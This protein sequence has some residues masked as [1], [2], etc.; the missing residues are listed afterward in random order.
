[1]TNR[2]TLFAAV[3][4][5]CVLTGAG[6]FVLGQKL[7]SPEDA[8]VEVAAPEPSLIG[9]P[10]ESLALSNDVVVRGDAQFEGAVDL[11]LD[12]SLGD[13][14]TRVV[15]NK[16]PTIDS[17][18]NEG[19]VLIEVSGRPVFL[20]E[21]ELPAFREFKPGLEGDDVLQLE[22]ALKRLGYLEVEPDR[23]YGDATE[24]AIAAMYE[25]AGYEA[26]AASEAEENQLKSA[27]DA[28]S[29]AR[30][31]LADA[32][33]ALAKSSQTKTNSQR[34]QEQMTR[35]D[36][37]EAIAKAREALEKLESSQ[38]PAIIS[39]MVALEEAN[40]TY[41]ANAISSANSALASAQESRREQIRQA[42]Q[43]L[44][45]AQ[46]TLDDADALRS[47]QASDKTD[48]SSAAN[49]VTRAQE[50]LERAEA[51]LAKLE[52]EIGVRL[53]Q[54]EVVFL[55]SVPRTV[56]A[57][58]V[59]RGDVVTG[60][61]MRISGTEV[62]IVSA[63]SEANRRLL[64]VG[65]KVIIDSAQLGI[66]TG[67]VIKEIADRTGTNGAANNRYHM[68]VVPEGD[69][70]VSEMVGL[71]FRI[72]IPLEKSEGDVLA[73]PLAALSAGADGSSRVEVIIEGKQTRLVPVEVGLSD[74]NRSLVEIK[75][76]GGNIS[77]G[78]MVVVGVENGKETTSTGDAGEAGDAGEPAQP[79]EKDAESEAGESGD[80]QEDK[81]E[82]GN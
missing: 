11:K 12:T 23:L 82:G 5:V 7:K 45:S 13:G 28:V 36:Q 3:V 39:A 67:G 69:Y 72:K 47:A 41:D 58:D 43:A 38:S 78:D 34:L 76:I 6:G 2:K 59:S 19:D 15:T 25:A 50:T 65:Q 40:K 42:Q 10:V 20:L 77:A 32:K 52:E 17:T 29:N 9:V 63:V 68:V 51:D 35:R 31:S 56:T 54:A 75:P 60:S 18:V 49:Q 79:G 37:L 55:K 21:G 22:Q 24:K 64:N 80:V 48:N 14:K 4:A 8:R 71:N 62:R 27:R 74:K 33:D 70:K 44:A 53:P 81:S 1:M 26:R 61:V 57:V 46:Q 16:V 66:E 30:K 73:V